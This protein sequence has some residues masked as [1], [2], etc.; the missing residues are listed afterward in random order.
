M[1]EISFGLGHCGRFCAW[2]DVKTCNTISPAH[3]CAFCNI[4]ETFLRLVQPQSPV[5]PA[6][7]VD[8]NGFSADYFGCR[9]LITVKGRQGLMTLVWNAQNPSLVWWDVFSL[10]HFGYD[11]TDFVGFN[12]LFVVWF[13]NDYFYWSLFVMCLAI[14]GGAVSAKRFLIRVL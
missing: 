5:S 10:Y 11:A 1:I 2:L 8:F 9:R 4:L 14:N 13:S 6:F 12:W 3:W 7:D